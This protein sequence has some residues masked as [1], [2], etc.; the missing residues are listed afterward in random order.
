ML[1]VGTAIDLT[2][3]DVLVVL[4]LYKVYFKKNHFL[5]SLNNSF[6]LLLFLILNDYDVFFGLNVFIRFIL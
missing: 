2:C 1:I 4:E 6:V 5:V 3:L